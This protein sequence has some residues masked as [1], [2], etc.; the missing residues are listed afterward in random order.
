MTLTATDLAQFTGTEYWYKHPLF[1]GYT[2]TDGVRYVAREA[3]AYWL[4]E[5]ILS[6]QLS[7]QVNREPFQTWTLTRI[8]TSKAV[9]VCEDGN[10]N[11]VTRQDI[12]YTDFPLPKITMYLT[13]RVLLLPSE[14]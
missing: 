1:P 5:A 7:P 6:H 4:I 2:Y 12:N 10:G 13:D 3:G 9:L 11:Q 8:E 14:Y